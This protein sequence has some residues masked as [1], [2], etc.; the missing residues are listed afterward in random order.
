MTLRLQT[1]GKLTISEEDIQSIKIG[2]II[3]F[4]SKSKRIEREDLFG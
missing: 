1:F 3:E 2:K 4:I